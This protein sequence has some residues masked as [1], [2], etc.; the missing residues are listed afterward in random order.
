MKYLVTD[1]CYI[2]EDE[3]WDKLCAKAD[4]ITNHDEGNRWSNAFDKLVENHLKEL[5]GVAYVAGTGFGD[6]TNEIDGKRFVADAGMVTVV[7]A[8]KIPQKIYEEYNNH[9]GAIVEVEDNASVFLDTSN[10]DWT[11]VKVGEFESLP[12]DNEE[13]EE[14]DW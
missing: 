4:E 8:E 3:M 2:V 1:P 9:L 6:W 7:P 11:V 5:Y 13:D 10:P 12:Y 14:A